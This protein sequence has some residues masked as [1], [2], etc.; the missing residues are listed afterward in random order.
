MKKDIKLIELKEKI[1]E[2]KKKKE[3]QENYLIGV[4]FGSLTFIGISIFVYVKK[5]EIPEKYYPT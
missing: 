1:S 3:E 2:A 4:F 5:H